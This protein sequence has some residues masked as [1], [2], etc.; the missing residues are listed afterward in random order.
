[1]VQTSRLQ[2]ANLVFSLFSVVLFVFLLNVETNNTINNEKLFD[3]SCSCKRLKARLL[4]FHNV[5]QKKE[6]LKV[7]F[8]FIFLIRQL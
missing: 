2:Y 8:E 6:T 7:V 1:M 4:Y 3:L 5:F